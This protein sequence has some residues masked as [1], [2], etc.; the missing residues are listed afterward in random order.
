MFDVDKYKAPDRKY[1]PIQILHDFQ[2]VALN[3]QE[4]YS[5]VVMKILCLVVIVIEV[6][7]V[8]SLSTKA[9]NM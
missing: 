3:V 4:D 8:Q 1:A 5:L 9:I 6:I 2:F 7:F